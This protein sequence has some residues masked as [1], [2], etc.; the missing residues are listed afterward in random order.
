LIPLAKKSTRH[1]SLTFS[2]VI[3]QHFIRYQSNKVDDDR[4]KTLEHVNDMMRDWD[5]RVLT[6]EELKPKTLNPS[7]VSRPFFLTKPSLFSFSFRMH[8]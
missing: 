8:T 5:A 6:Y 4:K 2:P 3:R 7:P 1:A